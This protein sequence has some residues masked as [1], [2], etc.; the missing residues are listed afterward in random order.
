MRIVNEKKA[1]NNNINPLEEPVTVA[2]IMEREVKIPDK[3]KT[4]FQIM[5]IGIDSGNGLTIRKARLIE[6]SSADAVY[7][8]SGG[9]Q[10]TGKDLSS[11]VTVKTMTESR[12]SVTLLNKS[13]PCA[14]NETVRR[15]DMG[16]ESNISEANS[17][18]PS[19]IE[20]RA[21]LSTGIG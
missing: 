18:V 13:G 19:H 10:L 5:Y 4:F 15:I 9:K 20:K 7:A 14:S 12:R 16:M 6:S 8:C 2:G 3:V 21:D 17:L 1:L 11:S